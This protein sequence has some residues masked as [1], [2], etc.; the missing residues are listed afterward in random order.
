MIANQ[1]MYSGLT[2]PTA[3]TSAI[4]SSGT[5]TVTGT[6]ENTGDQTTG[7]VWVVATF[8]NASGTVVGLNY[9]DYLI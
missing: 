5:Y 1:T 7:Y 4:D 6:V 8:Y 9:T 3:S 2:I